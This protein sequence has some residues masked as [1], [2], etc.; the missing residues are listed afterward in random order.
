MALP[1]T[2]I[3]TPAPKASKARVGYQ[4]H[5][6]GHD[7]CGRPRFFLPAVSR[8]NCMMMQ[9]IE[10]SAIMAPSRCARVARRISLTGYCILCASRVH[11]Q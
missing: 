2:A 1:V 3:A 10:A 4:Y 8:S 11:S 9:G 6:K 7:M 5:P